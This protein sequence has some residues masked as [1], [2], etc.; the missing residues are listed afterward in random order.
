MARVNIDTINANNRLKKG[1]NT[2][3]PNSLHGKHEMHGSQKQEKSLI[4]SQK[5]FLNSFMNV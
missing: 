2:S 5:Q 4:R 3:F 1:L